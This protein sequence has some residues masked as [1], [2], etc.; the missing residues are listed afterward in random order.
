MIE[1]GQINLELLIENDMIYYTILLI[2]S[3]L[4]GIVRGSM[5]SDEAIAGNPAYKGMENTNIFHWGI[6]AAY[7]LIGGF[8]FLGIIQLA[9]FI[10][11]EFM[12]T[13]GFAGRALLINYGKKAEATSEQVQPK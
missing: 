7:G 8:I 12:P 3:A 2:I 1:P 13:F 10:P 6:D 9:G 5:E 11:L 4:A